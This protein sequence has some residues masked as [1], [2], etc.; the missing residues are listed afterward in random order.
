MV[1]KG[2]K[3]RRTHPPYLAVQGV[4]LVKLQSLNLCMLRLVL[5]TT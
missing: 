3:F 2:L 1:I 5:S 4:K